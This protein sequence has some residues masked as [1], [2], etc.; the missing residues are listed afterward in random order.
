[1]EWPWFFCSVIFLLDFWQDYIS[2]RTHGNICVELLVKFFVDYMQSDLMI[3]TKL[4]HYLWWI[5]NVIFVFAW[6]QG[7][8]LIHNETNERYPW[9]FISRTSISRG[10]QDVCR[11]SK[12]VAALKRLGTIAKG[13]IKNSGWS[14][15]KKLHK[16]SFH[17]SGRNLLRN[18]F[19]EDLQEFLN[20]FLQSP[21]K[22]F[23]YRFVQSIVSN[24]KK[25]FSLLAKMTGEIHLRFSWKKSE[26]HEFLEELMS[27]VLM[28]R[29]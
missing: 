16:D 22:S 19:I 10:P 20:L 23:S 15:S 12:W 28:W 8:H 25:A 26:K 21:S 18:F 13:A 4:L 6:S 17:N 14:C 5:T 11:T 24:K 3:L 2:Y 27:F 7:Y 29:N 9:T 1:M